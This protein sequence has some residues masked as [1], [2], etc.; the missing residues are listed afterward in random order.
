MAT[1]KINLFEQAI[2]QHELAEFGLG[3][4]EYFIL[5]REYDGHWI[6]GSW[7]RYI[8]PFMA[9]NS[10]ETASPFLVQMVRELMVSRLADARERNFALLTHVRIHYYYKTKDRIRLDA[11]LV[12]D[13]AVERYLED[14]AGLLTGAGESEDAGLIVHGI[15]MIRKYGGFKH[16]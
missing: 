12:E 5:D 14:Y 1:D 11:F 7:D 13:D 3:K 15:D 2:R 4:K 9:D 10:E 16:S 8:L 6:L